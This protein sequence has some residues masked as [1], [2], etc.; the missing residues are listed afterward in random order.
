MKEI[1]RMNPLLV[2][3]NNFSWTETGRLN[4]ENMSRVFGCDIISLNIN[5]K[6]AQKMLWKAFVK[7]GSPTWLWDLAV[8]VFPVRLAINY[9]IPLIVY[10]EN[11][12]VEY[13][14]DQYEETYSAKN[15]ITN[16]IVKKVDWK[17]WLE[18]GITMRDFTQVIYPSDKEIEAAGLDPIYLG[19][20]VPW[21]GYKNMELATQYG[22][23]TLPWSEWKREGFIEDYDQIDAIG[24]LLHPW[25]KYPKYGHARATDI[26]STII[27]SGKLTRE[28]AIEL[29]RENDHKLDPRALQDFADFVK[30]PVDECLEIIDSWYNRNLFKR[31]GDKWELKNPIWKE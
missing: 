15:Q 30:H 31:V 12:D 2:N 27:R 21:D 5:R 25:M 23:R 17:Y 10:G 28:K 24:Y 1:M 4:F 8:Y 22:F 9:K 20:F 6:L 16:D 13:G 7:L 18:D 19:Y 26:A 14:G 11:V 29:V 3:V